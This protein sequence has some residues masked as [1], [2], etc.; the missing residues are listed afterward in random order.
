MLDER[1]VPSLLFG[2]FVVTMI[3]FAVLLYT[4]YY[5]SFSISIQQGAGYAIIL[6]IFIAII[7]GVLS[8]KTKT[9]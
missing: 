1:V 2:G 9:R 8:I 6:G 7:G 3:G 4:A 5:M